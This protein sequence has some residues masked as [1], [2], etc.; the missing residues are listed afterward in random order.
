[1]NPE[2]PPGVVQAVVRIVSVA[3]PVHWD[4]AK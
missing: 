4:G 3:V 2:L 1:V